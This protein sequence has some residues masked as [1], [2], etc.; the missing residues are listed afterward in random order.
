MSQRKKKL[1]AA[2]CKDIYDEIVNEGEDAGKRLCVRKG[3]KTGTYYR[4][5]NS[6]GVIHPKWTH[7][8]HSTKWSELL[9]D[10]CCD[11]ISKNPILTLEEIIAKMEHEYKAPSI[12]KTTLSSYLKFSLISYKSV[13]YHAMAR[14]T[15]ETK[16]KRIKYGEFYVQNDDLNF[17]FIDEVGYSIALQRSRGRAPIGQRL[18]QK[19]PTLKSPNISICMAISKDQIIHYKKKIDAYDAESFNTF[20][21]ELV[22]IIQSM[23]LT[24]V[25]LV[26]DNCRAHR[27]TDISKICSGV[28]QY[29]FLPPY[30]PN[31]N[32]IENIFGILKSH[33]KKLLA[34]TYRNDL[35][36]TF[37]LPWGQKGASR[38]AI[39]DS[40][41]IESLAEITPEILNDTFE[42]M[43]KFVYMSL[44]GKDI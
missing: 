8:S 12:S 34:T 7:P 18:I 23:N 20:V 33:M 1:T 32:P 40:T 31:L 9:I 17:I 11:L 15:D 16:Q 25:C 28:V 36:A 10:L 29:R 19:L 5:R 4:C 41:F 44:E 27:E 21:K 39:L 2:D 37:D 35:L 43:K 30:S 14:N 38:E 22:E 42:H 26:M 24:N 3:Y 13:D 6:K